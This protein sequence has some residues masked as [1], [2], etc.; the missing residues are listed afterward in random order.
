MGWFPYH[1]LSY[2]S[3]WL[4]YDF[5]MSSP[6]IH[7]NN[8]I[9]WFHHVWTKYR[10]FTDFQG[11]TKRSST[12]FHHAL[13]YTFISTLIQNDLYLIRWDVFIWYKNIIQSHV[14]C[15]LVVIHTAPNI[16]YML[17]LQMAESHFRLVKIQIVLEW[18]FQQV[19]FGSSY[20]M[21]IKGSNRS[22]N[23]Y[24]GV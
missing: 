8:K 5:T 11:S 14:K 20:Y 23:G 4:S 7:Y 3:P 16:L 12:V 17:T 2:I 1:N 13:N 24:K 21:Y 10:L 19:I 9:H 15:M 18:V 22:Q 6:F